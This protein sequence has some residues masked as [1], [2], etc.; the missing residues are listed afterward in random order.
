LRSIENIA[1][2]LRCLVLLVMQPVAASVFLAVVE[3]HGG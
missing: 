1:V 2:A 3:A